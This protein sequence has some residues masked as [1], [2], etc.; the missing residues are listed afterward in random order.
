MCIRDRDS[1]HNSIAY[2]NK[3]SGK[4]IAYESEDYVS[5][6]SSY[7]TSFF[8][9]IIE[10]LAT[11]RAENGASLQR[12]NYAL[13]QADLERAKLESANGVIMDVDIA[14]ESTSLAKWN[15]L[16]QAS[17]SMLTQANSAPNVALML[18]M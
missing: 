4:T 13:E 16:V 18:L 3:A 7:S 14:T 8:T 6:L 11:L 1:S 9:T 5:L 15:I 2:Q 12:L 10:N 17:A